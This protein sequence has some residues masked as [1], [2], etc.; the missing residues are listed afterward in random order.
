MLPKHKVSS[1]E[2]GQILQN[3]IIIL[4]AYLAYIRLIAVWNL[5]IR[6]GCWVLGASTYV[7]SWTYKNGPSFSFFHICIQ[8][9]LKASLNLRFKKLFVFFNELCSLVEIIEREND[10]F[11]FMRYNLVLRALLTLSNQ[12][13]WRHNLVPELLFLAVRIKKNR[14]PWERGCC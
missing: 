2:P 13:P 14:E 10:S 12:E 8:L 7:C 4:A 1:P 3:T 9:V 11:Y 5:N 6:S